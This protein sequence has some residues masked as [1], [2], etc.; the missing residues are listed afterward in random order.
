[1]Y[2]LQFFL[3]KILYT[4]FSVISIKMAEKLA[5]FFA[6]I[7]GNIFRYRRKTILDNLYKVYGDNLPIKKNILVRDI[8]RNFTYLWFEVL[9]AKKITPYNFDTHFNIHGFETIDKYLKH[10][11]GLILI[12]GHFGNFEWATIWS[13]P[14]YVGRGRKAG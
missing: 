4:V 7:L 2:K 6:F 12:S 14:S 5:D 11:K 13:G 3:F 9:H 1:M 8:Y 10:K